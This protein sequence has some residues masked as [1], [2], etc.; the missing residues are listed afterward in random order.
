MTDRFLIVR[1][2]IQQTCITRIARIEM[3]VIHAAKI[4][5]IQGIGFL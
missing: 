1:E 4:Q 3:P 5:V 2:S